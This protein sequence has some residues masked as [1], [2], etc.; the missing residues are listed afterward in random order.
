MIAV[1]CIDGPNEGQVIDVPEA[2][3]FRVPVRSNRNHRFLD[4]SSLDDLLFQVAEYHIYRFSVDAQLNPFVSV[5]LWTFAAS[6]DSTSPEPRA[7]PVP[8]QTKVFVDDPPNILE[9]FERW[10]EYKCYQHGLHCDRQHGFAVE[11][12]KGVAWHNIER[13]A[14]QVSSLPCELPIEAGW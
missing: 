13:A 3:S 9:D 12:S 2:Q 4:E 5:C 6:V 8:P 7:L 10:W 14:K 11:H 1:Y